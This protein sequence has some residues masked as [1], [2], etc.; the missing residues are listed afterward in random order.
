MSRFALQKNAIRRPRKMRISRQGVVTVLSAFLMVVCFAFVSFAVDTGLIVMTKNQMQN[1]VDAAA[2]AASQEIVSAVYNAGQIGSA[3]GATQSATSAARQVAAQV[4]QANGVYI[5]P[6]TDVTFG[7]RSFNKANNTWPIAWGTAPYNVV[8]V[9]ARRENADL[10][11]NDG[12]LKLA[13]GWAVNTPS[14]PLRISASAFVQA[15]D[16]VLVMDYSGS[17]NDDSTFY[18]FNKL[19][20]S[21]V[22]ANMA[23]IFNTINPNVGTLPMTPAWPRFKGV[24]PASGS[25]PQIYVTYQNSQ[26]YVES[27]KALQQVKLQFSGGATQTFTGLSATTGTFKGSGSNTG[28]QVTICWVKSANNSTNGEQFTDDNATVMKAYGLNSISYPY[29]SGSWDAFLTYCRNDSQVNNAGYKLKYGKLSFVNYLETT[30]PQYNRTNVLWKTP[31]YPFHAIKEGATLFTEFLAD[32][33]FDDRLGLVTYD[34]NSRIEKVLST[35]G[36]SVDISS[37]PIT[38]YYDKINTIQRH[39]QSSH[40]GTYTAIGYGVRDARTLLTDYAREGA[41]KTIILMTD[42][43]A[44]RA[45]SGWSLPST[46]KWKDYT[47]YDGNGTADYTSGDVNVAYAFHQASLAIAEGATIHTISV[48]ADGDPQLMAA[49]A[50]AGGGITVNVPGGST[51]AQMET[52]LQ[53]AFAKIASKLPPPKLVYDQN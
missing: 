42:G 20:K 29:N 18:A 2:L 1:A 7:R 22:E 34:E 28:K 26:V 44:N 30:Q 16:M 47:D 5:N 40:Y 23:E 9:T 51:V 21:A 12:R 31:A 35:D 17:M 8:K 36:A 33:S 10:N 24:A 37:E 38:P 50:F 4:A 6:E 52:E 19:G 48:G 45:P 13:F 15:R 41:N 46:F 43:L 25:L 11:P 27:S 49:I 3:G 32:L 39:K 14:I 53:A